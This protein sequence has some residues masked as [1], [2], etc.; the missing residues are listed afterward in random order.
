MKGVTDNYET[1]EHVTSF[2]TAPAP[3]TASVSEVRTSSFKIE[4][5]TVEGAA[6][7]EL[8]MFPSP[9]HAN[10]KGLI[11]V[12]SSR[13]SFLALNLEPAMDYKINLGKLFKFS[14]IG[15]IKTH[16]LNMRRVLRHVSINI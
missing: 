13:N 8:E 15:R 3:P 4:W 14:L 12:P 10:E 1:D 2:R 7:Y 11:I 9:A 16:D 5:T 6:H